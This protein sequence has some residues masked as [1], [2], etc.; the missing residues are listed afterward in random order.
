MPPKKGKAAVKE[1]TPAELAAVMNKRFGE[2]T[3]R[4]ASDPSLEVQRLPSGILTVDVL[5]GG[6]FPRNRH[7]ELFGGASVGKS[8]LA[9]KVIASVQE[10]GGRGAWVDTEKSFEPVFA[11][12]CGID[13]DEL[14]YHEQEHGPKCVNA[15]ETWLRSELYDVIVC[16]SISALLPIYEFE[17]EMGVGSMGME[18]AKLMSAALRKLTAA[19]KSTAVIWINQTRDSVGGLVF[20]K[21]TTTSG[22]RAMGF[23]AGVRL[24]LVKVETM[25][26][27][28]RKVN[29]KTGV[30]DDN[31][32]VPYGH[33]VLVRGAKDKTGGLYRPDDETS[34]VFDYEAGKH[35]HIEDLIY[36]GLV[37]DYIGR[38]G[39]WWWVEDYEDN[40][41]NGRPRFKKW[42]EANPEVCE[43]LEGWIR[44][45]IEEDEE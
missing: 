12:A 11:A 23:Y 30:I 44:A 34:F 13:L 40:R 31:A 22:G 3:M 24:E 18:Q 8:Y 10:A 35:D 6:G 41:K 28:G 7:S 36:L 43:E 32:D 17:N 33:R 9:Q 37:Y 39:D 29:P 4:M 20:G 16:D 27:K 15:M 14:A 42:L 26:K 21:K 1:M 19:N 45:E 5:T 38:K 25:K 2:G